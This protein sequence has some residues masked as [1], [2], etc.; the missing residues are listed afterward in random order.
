MVQERR[1]ALV[2]TANKE[3]VELTTSLP[4]P[5]SS[6]FPEPDFNFPVSKTELYNS[7]GAEL[8]QARYRARVLMH[9]FNH[10]I[11]EAPTTSKEPG[12]RKKLLA[13]LLGVEAKD[14]GDVYI[15]PP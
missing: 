1:A 12:E 15:E 5:P 3:T 8:T 11:P 13:E 14:M 9:K 6:L 7:F 2:E 10:S 4:S